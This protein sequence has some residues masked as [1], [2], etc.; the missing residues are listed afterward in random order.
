MKSI[1]AKRTKQMREII[2]VSLKFFSYSKGVNNY[3][4]LESWHFFLF[5]P[6]AIYSFSISLAL[7]IFNSWKDS[8]PHFSLILS[9]SLPPMLSLFIFNSL[10]I[11]LTEFLFHCLA[12]FPNLFST[13]LSSWK[14]S[15]S[16]RRFPSVETNRQHLLPFRSIQSF[17]PIQN[18]NLC[19]PPLNLAWVIKPLR[20][21]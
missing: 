1:L 21:L 15:R 18:P 12:L 9:L 8:P 10:C 13:S 16:L 19:A 3:L 14:A 5:S 2:F 4:F 11:S 17:W 20:C 7:S 6:Q